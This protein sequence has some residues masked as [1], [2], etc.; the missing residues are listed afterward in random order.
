V[1]HGGGS[2]NIQPDPPLRPTVSWPCSHYTFSQRLPF[3]FSRRRVECNP[4]SFLA[5]EDFHDPPPA[6]EFGGFVFF[7]FWLLVGLVVFLLLICPRSVSPFYCIRRPSAVPSRV[8]IR[9]QR[10]RHPPPPFLNPCFF[11]R[12][13]SLPDLPMILF[14][15]SE[16]RA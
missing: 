10:L 4:P 3:F 1:R 14:F 6:S 16:D 13:R 7:S 11:F 8:D 12:Q 5:T 15:L 9:R 2:L